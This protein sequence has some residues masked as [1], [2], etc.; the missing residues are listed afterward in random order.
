MPKSFDATSSKVINAVAPYL[1]E[2]IPTATANNLAD[3]GKYILDNKALAN[4]FLNVLVNRI[5]KVIITSRMYENPL[6]VFKKGSERYGDLIEEIY[7]NIANAHEFDP[8]IAEN[9]VYKRVIPDVGAVYHQ[10]NSQLYYKTT[11]SEDQLAKAFTSEQGMRTLIAGIV[12]SLYSGANYDEFLQMKNLFAESTHEFYRIYTDEPSTSTAKNIVTNFKSASNLLEFMSSSYNPVG[13]KNFTP[14][15]NQVLFLR[16]DV[17]AIIETNVLAAAFNLPYVDFLT[18]KINV[19]DFGVGNED[20]YAVLCDEEFLIVHNN[21]DKFTEI[22]NAQGLYWNYFWHVWRTY[23]RSPFSNMIAFCTGS[24]TAGTAVTI[25]NSTSATYAKGSNVQMTA[26]VTPDTAT[27]Q[28]VTWSLRGAN[29]DSY[30][31]ATGMV[32]LG[33]HQTGTLEIV[34]TL[35]SNP[36][37]KDVMTWTPSTG[38][39]AQKTYNVTVTAGS[40]GSASASPTSGANGT[41][42]TLTITPASG[43]VLDKVTGV[44]LDENNKFIIRDQDYTINVTFK[45]A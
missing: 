18:R 43:Y 35:A 27:N 23:S 5:V 11:I 22:Y 40:H 34:A 38:A 45:S 21:L 1:T 29:G 17:D 42:V 7:V 6:A 2:R 8:Q 33:N 44:T 32:H 16:A 4:Q 19:D 37:I 39:F 10:M 36:E 9:E 31:S 13:V 25:T 26:S 20:I 12:D 14:K 30:I 3:I 28:N 15:R 41:E 24:A